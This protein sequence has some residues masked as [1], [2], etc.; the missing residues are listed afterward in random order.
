MD[1][2]ILFS[3]VLIAKVSKTKNKM[4]YKSRSKFTE[5]GG[6]CQYKFQQI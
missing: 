5:T 6:K 1:I 3:A 4:Y 2:Q